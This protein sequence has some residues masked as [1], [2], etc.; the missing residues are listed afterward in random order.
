MINGLKILVY[1]LPY[2]LCFYW[3]LINHDS[4]RLKK[5]ELENNLKYIHTLSVD[6]ESELYHDYKFLT[7]LKP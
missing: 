7:T 6:H 2:S 5:H 4:E 3:K 1:F